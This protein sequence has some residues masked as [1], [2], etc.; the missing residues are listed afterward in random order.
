MPPPLHAWQRYLCH[1]FEEHLCDVTL[2]P[3]YTAKSATRTYALI[4]RS[5]AAVIGS[6][7]PSQTDREN[8]KA[9]PIKSSAQGTLFYGVPALRS[10]NPAK[11]KVFQFEVVIDPVFRAF[12]SKARLFDP[13]KGREL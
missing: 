12:A 8:P 13:A 1:R 3:W 10:R 9:L 6:T 5:S 11:A 7:P 2:L 4:A